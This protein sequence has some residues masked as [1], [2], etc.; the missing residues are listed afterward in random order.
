LV[1][2]TGHALLP[3]DLLYAFKIETETAYTLAIVIGTLTSSTLVYQEEGIAKG[4]AES[5][6]P[7]AGGGKASGSG[8]GGNLKRSAEGR[9]N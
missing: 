8:L 6:D 5:V 3:L 2:L 7:G 1:L 9:E 4:G